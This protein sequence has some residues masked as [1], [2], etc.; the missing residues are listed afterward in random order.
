MEYWGLRTSSLSGDDEA[1][2]PTPVENYTL[3]AGRTHYQPHVLKNT[4][5]V[6]LLPSRLLCQG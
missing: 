1:H 4:A 2:G 3:Q 6:K 5:F